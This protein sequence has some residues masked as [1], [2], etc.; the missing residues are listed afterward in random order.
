LEHS[1]EAN[2]KNDPRISLSFNSILSS[3]II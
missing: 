3:E 2:L 1:V